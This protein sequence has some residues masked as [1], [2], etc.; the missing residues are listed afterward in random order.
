MNQ[1]EFMKLL[2]QELAKAGQTDIDDILSDFAEHFA[3]GLASSK[4]ED[5]IARDLGDPAEIAAQYAADGTARPEG[6]A[7]ST[8]RW[9]AMPDS[10]TDATRQQAPPPPQPGSQGTSQRTGSTGSTPHPG[11]G[12][13]G[14]SAPGTVYVTKPDNRGW[15]VVLLVLL[16]LF[17][18]LPIFF[19]LIGVLL[20]LWAGAGGIGVAAG[21][22]FVLAIAKAGFTSIIFVLFGLSLTAL[23]VLAFIG[24]YYLTKWFIIGIGHYIRWNRQLVSGGAVA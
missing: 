17:V 23:T 13:A 5:E 3:G 24:V 2:R 14:Q 4:A 9:A 20:S 18:V 19:S 22:L 21:A 16:N 1:A 12:A 7:K 10:A 11:S 15:M 8:Y 6:A